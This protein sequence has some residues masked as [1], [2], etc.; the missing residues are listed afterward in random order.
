MISPVNIWV[1]ERTGLRVDLTPETLL[2]WQHE[3]LKRLIQYARKNCKFYHDK[4]PVE[5]ELSDLPFTY[6]ADLTADPFAFLAVSPSSVARVTTLAN[7]GT[8]RLKKR[9]FFS[10]ADIERTIDFFASGMKT[11]IRKGEHAQILLSNSTENSLG[12][13]LRESLSRIGVSSEITAAIKTAND[14]INASGEA[15]CLIGMPAE[16][17]YMSRIAPNLNPGSVLLAADYIPQSVVDSLKKTWKCNVF[18]HYGHTEFGFGCAVDCTQHNGLHIRDADLI[19]EIIDPDTGKAANC[20]E[21]G[22]IVVTTLSNEAMPLIRYRTG[23]ISRFI[24]SPCKCGGMLPRLG[25]IEGRYEN[26]ITVGDNE[27][28]SINRLDEIIFADANVRGYNA[29][30]K[31]EKEKITL[32]LTVDSISTMDTDLLTSKLPPGLNMVV[33]YDSADPFNNR[34]KRRLIIE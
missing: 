32:Q 20:G 25:R 18:S 15:N 21:S 7:S 30:L 9:I 14:A 12:S 19:V 33:K 5:T 2:Q 4:L 27:T 13:L 3:K 23:N 29:S 8:T 22:E 16:I 26:I 34:M 10:K 24:N 17:L 11:M 6:P 28:I 1:A 31:H